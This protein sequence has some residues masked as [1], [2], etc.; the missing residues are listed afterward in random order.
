MALLAALMKAQPLQARQELQ[1]ECNATGLTTA[2]AARTHTLS[3][4]ILLD[5]SNA[6]ALALGVLA[7]HKKLSGL[8][9]SSVEHL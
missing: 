3:S 9:S 7:D 2:A 8:S 5:W 6:V 1:D 4:L